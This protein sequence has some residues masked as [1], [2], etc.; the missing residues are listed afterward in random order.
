MP[1]QR[2]HQFEV[3][4]RAVPTVKI[5]KLRIQSTLESLL[6]HFREMIVFSFAVRV[7]IKNAVIN[8][9][10][11]NA[12]RPE[13]A[14]Q[15]DSIDDRTSACPTNAGKQARFSPNTASQVSNRQ[16]PEYRFANQSVFWIPARVFRH[17]VRDAKAVE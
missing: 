10:A 16:A 3:F 12:V 7:F 17:R 1:T 9:D 13:Q 11:S 2:T 14:N 4:N 5:H 6:Q 8:W 15:V